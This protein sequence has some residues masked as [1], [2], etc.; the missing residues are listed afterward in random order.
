MKSASY[1]YRKMSNRRGEK[2]QDMGLLEVPCFNVC[3]DAI[4]LQM[5]SKLYIPIN[6]GLIIAEQYN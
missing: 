6:T 1:E 4:T 3:I 2:F 5:T